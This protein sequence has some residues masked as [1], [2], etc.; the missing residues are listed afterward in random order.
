MIVHE[1]LRWMETAPAAMRAN[2]AHALARAYL[3]SEVDEETRSAMEAAMTVLLDDS[4]RDVRFAL[5]DALAS[6]PAAPRH[7]LLMLATDQMDIAGLVLARSPVFI[8]A[9]LVDIVA[10]SCERLQTA[11]AERPLVSG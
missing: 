4:S 3:Y 9:E 6:S 10:A 8:D 1:F 5:A 7:V 11:I 2:A